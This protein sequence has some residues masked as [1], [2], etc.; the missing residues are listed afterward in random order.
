MT[1]KLFAGLDPGKKR[2]FTAFAV[3]ESQAVQRAPL[4]GSF[5]P[6]FVNVYTIRDLVR[7][8]QDSY[9][10]MS[11]R[12]SARLRNPIMKDATLIVDETGIGA[13]VTDMMRKRGWHPRPV[14][15]TGGSK[16]SRDGAYGYHIPKRDLVT[17]VG[18]LLESRRLRIPTS[19]PLAQTLAE[20]LHNFKVTISALGHDSYGAGDDWREGSHDDLVLAVALAAWFGENV[21]QSG[22]SVTTP[23]DLPAA[24]GGPLGGPPKWY[25]EALAEQQR[26]R[27]AEE[28]EERV[29]RNAERRHGGSAYPVD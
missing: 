15:I 25:L 13:A 3:L 17:T 23:W 5:V 20:E 12:V 16:V 28:E 24:S 8:Q 18:L 26:Q 2:D 10:N 19:L 1:A 27:E 4:P 11:N 6:H 21:S 14:T 7:W 9:E 29:R 22:Y